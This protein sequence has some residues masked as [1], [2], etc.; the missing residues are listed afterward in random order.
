MSPTPRITGLDWALMGVLSVAWSGSY[1]MFRLLVPVLPPL[2]IALLRVALGAFCLHAWMA[3]RGRHLRRPPPGWL[4]FL[5]L[6]LLNN[7]IP[8][9]LIVW[10]ERRVSAGLTAILLAATPIFTT[11]LAQ[12]VGQARLTP[13]RAGGVVLGF[14]GVAI[15]I[16]PDALA[17]LSTEG[18][19]EEGGLLLA[20]LSYAFAG[21]YARRFP[22]VPAIQMA[23]GQLSGATVV[24]LPAALLAEHPWALPPIGAATW[25][26]LA[27]LVI[28]C[29]ALPFILFFFLLAR[30][31][32]SNVL[33]VTFLSP[34]TTLVL[35]N[36]L[37]GEQVTAQ[38]LAG[39]A[40]VILGLVCIDGRVF[41]RRAVAAE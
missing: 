13:S 16:G 41:R 36:L 40:V 2:T 31:G 19:A 23:A 37:L 15:L 25:L 1:L 28:P 5:L 17:G 20:A 6:G 27:V 34:A 8:F 4:G 33:L 3:L 18:L 39:M 14:I 38:A 26:D 30:V 24:L 29:T 22:G 12:L 11:L 21:L 9:A 35:G 32:A 7:G 10:A